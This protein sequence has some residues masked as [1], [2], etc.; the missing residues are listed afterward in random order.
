MCRYH[1]ASWHQGSHWTIVGEYISGLPTSPE[2]SF[3]IGHWQTMLRQN[4]TTGSAGTYRKRPETDP[5]R[6]RLGL[7][8]PPKTD[9]KHI[10]RMQSRQW[11]DMF[12]PE[13]PG[14]TKL[15]AWFVTRETPPALRQKKFGTAG[16]PAYTFSILLQFTELFGKKVI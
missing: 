7:W 13:F 3:D 10:S 5:T 14:L 16:C 11:F 15:G 1:I 2:P 12:C 9:P 8:Q 4:Q 6:H